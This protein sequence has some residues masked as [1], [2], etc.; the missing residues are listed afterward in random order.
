MALAAAALAFWK[1]LISL[2]GPLTHQGSSRK[3]DLDLHEGHGADRPMGN[4]GANL[5]RGHL[6][7]RH[8]EEMRKKFIE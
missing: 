4:W 7:N 3:F 6:M 2:Y 1:V 8:K 5:K